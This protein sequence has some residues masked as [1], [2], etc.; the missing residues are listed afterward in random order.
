MIHMVKN[1]GDMALRNF[2]PEFQPAR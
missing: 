1:I 2:V